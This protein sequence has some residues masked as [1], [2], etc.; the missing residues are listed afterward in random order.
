MDHSPFL[1]GT[2]FT[3]ACICACVYWYDWS[4][5]EWTHSRKNS[6]QRISW[7]PIKTKTLNQIYCNKL[8]VVYIHIY[9]WYQL[10]AGLHHIDLTDEVDQL[11]K[12]GHAVYTARLC[13]CACV[14]VCVHAW[15]S[16]SRVFLNTQLYLQHS[17]AFD[18]CACLQCTVILTSPTC[19]H[20]YIH[21]HTGMH[22]W[23]FHCLVSANSIPCLP[24]N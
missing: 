24:P 22:E 5:C 2:Q 6:K 19:L 10:W 14:W 18:T 15:V 9:I 16:S 23:C 4:E 12:D 21:I 7:L 11:S 3:S 1:L 8:S 17:T 13:V 20:W